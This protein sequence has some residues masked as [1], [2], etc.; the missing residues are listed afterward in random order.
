VRIGI[1]DTGKGITEEKK[2]MIFEPFFSSGESSGAVDPGVPISKKI[3]EAHG[4]F[5][6]VESRPG[7]GTTF[8]L[9]F[10]L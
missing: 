3:V 2:A 4:G 1:G 6:K 5:I 8:C 9:Y 10:P 7:E